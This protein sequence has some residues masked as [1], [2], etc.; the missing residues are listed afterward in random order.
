VI[1]HHF[2]SDAL[3][4]F[5]LHIGDTPVIGVN[6]LHPDG[7]QRFTLAHEL[8]HLV[9]GHHADFHIDLFSP[10]SAGDPPEY[11]WRHERA[12]NVF[13]A[14]LLM[15]ASL[16]RRDRVDG[17]QSLSV[18]ARRYKVS[19]EAMGIRLIVLGLS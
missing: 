10:V 4:G 14:S 12:A 6:A 11:D 19:E 5:L 2:S 15:P 18:L 13:A 1:G 3:S 8:G 7:R 16:V 9:L 17:N